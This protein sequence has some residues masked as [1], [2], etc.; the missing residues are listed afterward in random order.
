MARPSFC[1]ACAGD[2]ALQREERD[3]VARES[4]REGFLSTP[5]DAF[6]PDTTESGETL[7]GRRLGPYEVVSRIG[8]GGMGDVYKARDTRL[9]RT[10]AVKVPKAPYS[11]RFR[12]EAS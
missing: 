6:P 8:G 4:K 3:C 9:A 2:N 11:D 12:R 1:Q 5:G 10:V 7:I